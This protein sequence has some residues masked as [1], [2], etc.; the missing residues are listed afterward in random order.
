MTETASAMVKSDTLGNP[1]FSLATNVASLRTALQLT[2]LP[3]QPSPEMVKA[4]IDLI[5]EESETE[6]DFVCRIWLAMEAAAVAPVLNEA[7]H[8]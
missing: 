8:A 3:F 5:L 2:T 4:T 7:D 1:E 6:D